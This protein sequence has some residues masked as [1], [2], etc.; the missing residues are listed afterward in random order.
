MSRTYISNS[1][2]ARNRAVVLDTEVEVVFSVMPIRPLL[3]KE[4][5][6]DH[7]CIFELRCGVYLDSRC[8]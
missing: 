3:A 5:A 8:Q 6:F 2:V 4:H 7:R 1:F